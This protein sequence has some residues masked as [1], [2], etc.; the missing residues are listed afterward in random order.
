MIFCCGNVSYAKKNEV[1]TAAY[2]PID[3]RPGN[4]QRVE[5]AAEAS[6]IELYVPDSTIIHTSLNNQPLNPNGRQYG[7]SAALMKWI[8]EMDAKT[9]NFIISLDQLLSG[10]LV[11]S[12]VGGLLKNE[13][14]IIDKIIELAKKNN[15]YIFDTVIRLSACTVGYERGTVEVYD[16]MREYFDRSADKVYE[17]MTSKYVQEIVTAQVARQRKL[18]IIKYMLQHDNTGKIKYYIGVDDSSSRENIQTDEL[19][20]ITAWLRGRGMIYSGTDEIGLMMFSDLV[21]KLYNAD[22]KA[23]VK[24][25]GGNEDNGTEY[26]FDT[27]RENVESHI[28]GAGANIV[29]DISE[30]DMQIFVMTLH[31]ERKSQSEY[32]RDLLNE[33]TCSSLPVVVIDVAETEYDAE[34]NTYHRELVK[35]LPYINTSNLLAF[36]CWNGGG[37]AVGMAVGNGV[38]RMAYLKKYKQS[39]QKAQ[40]AYE[41]EIIFSF[42]KDIGYKMMYDGAEQILT[43]YL[44]DRGYSTSNFYEQRE[45]VE[46]AM[47]N[48]LFTE[49][50]A[51]SVA[52]IN[53]C[54]SGFD[55]QGRLTHSDIKSV[56]LSNYRAP[57]YRTFE[58]NFDI[59][60]N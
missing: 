11:H 14:D 4:L 41:K 7:D 53:K 49:C 1:Y 21:T 6:G 25:F 5:Y 37:N 26:D 54:I 43:K 46:W 20:Q 16:Y 34:E 39:S 31:D 13:T 35:M 10:G 3:D 19:E 2:I 36:S 52:G 29:E 40:E 59:T 22:I 60:V 17:T 48:G 30:A 32:T 47:N 45:E 27:V 28:K 12:R 23:Y 55:N 44:S 33:Y 50:M 8:K 57:W 18:E 9:D 58:V 24:Y 38:S 51:R 15:V 56:K 42:A